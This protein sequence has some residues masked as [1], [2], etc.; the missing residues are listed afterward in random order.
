L[1]VRPVKQRIS[2]EVIEADKQVFRQIRSRLE[3]AK[4][5]ASAAHACTLT[6]AEEWLDVAEEE[7]DENEEGAILDLTLRESQHLL[8]SSDHSEEATPATNLLHDSSKQV[9]PDLWQQLHQLK[10]RGPACACSA[11]ARLEVQ[12]VWV[13]HEALEGASHA[14]PYIETAE[15]LAEAARR[16]ADETCPLAVSL[17]GPV[18]VESPA[19]LP[20]PEEPVPA[21]HSPDPEPPIP[22]TTAAPAPEETPPVPEPPAP[23]A[24]VE[25][26]QQPEPL[27]E[28]EL[29]PEPPADVISLATLPWSVHFST[30]RATI[31][32]STAKVLNQ[33]S[34]VLRRHPIAQIRLEG[35]A[36]QRG[37]ASYNKTLSER[38]TQAVKAFLVKAGIPADH[39]S[40]TA[41]GKSQPLS[42]SRQNRELARNR[43]V[44][45][46]VTNIEEVRSEEQYAD[47]QPDQRRRKRSASEVQP[48]GPSRS[49]KTGKKNRAQVQR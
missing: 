28:P 15:R 34:D 20:T 37:D 42:R 14:R 13:D 7:Y 19:P 32:S 11:L 16:D 23:I 35:H 33:M 45:I 46:V 6:K 1:T 47:L 27:A 49:L 29:L 21:V 3:S 9:R 38:R 18:L 25:H 41:F 26:R 39:I 12:L 48:S 8:R 5:G 2:D 10:E 17:P 36:D 30:N 22:R 31:S 24:M 40:T 44:V 4:A 43:R